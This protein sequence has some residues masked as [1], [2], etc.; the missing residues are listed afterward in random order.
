MKFRAR[1]VG[2][3][4]GVLALL[5]QTAVLCLHMPAMQLGL[6]AHHGMAHA[7]SS[8]VGDHAAHA[9]LPSSDNGAPPAKST[10]RYCPICFALH[11]LAGFVPPPAIELSAPG[12]GEAVEPGIIVA[13][14]L[15]PAAHRL[16]QSRA[17]PLRV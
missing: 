5:G 6:V 17:P 14:E 3:V 16:P 11:S 12:I 13:V 9:A 1:V 8:E 15:Q 4:L 7:A 10:P 2:V